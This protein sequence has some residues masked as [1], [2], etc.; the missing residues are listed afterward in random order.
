MSFIVK[1]CFVVILIANNI[2]YCNAQPKQIS[3]VIKAGTNIASSSNKALQFSAIGFSNVYAFQKDVTINKKMSVGIGI[4]YLFAIQYF[5]N[6]F[7]NQEPQF[8]SIYLMHQLFTNNIN[9][10]IYISYHLPSAKNKDLNL[11]GG[12]GIGYTFYGF[13]NISKNYFTNNKFSQQAP[14][15]NGASTNLNRVNASFFIGAEKKFSF[16]KKQFLYWQILYQLDAG[17]VNYQTV[18]DPINDAF[19]LNNHSILFGIRKLIF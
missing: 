8:S 13:R 4:Q 17:A 9:I 12:A 11:L 15:F 1:I 18:N 3:I 7:E 14:V 16:K 10:P 6:K 2:I 5:K 19:M